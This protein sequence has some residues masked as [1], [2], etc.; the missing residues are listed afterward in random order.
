MWKAKIRFLTLRKLSRTYL[1]G[2]FLF[3]VY[4]IQ[5]HKINML[6]TPGLDDFIGGVVSSL[7]VVD[8]ALMI[9]NAQNGV[10]VG[11]KS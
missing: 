3:V 7:P 11:P 9:I 6:D 1:L 10:E 8:A 4:R 2:L 5:H